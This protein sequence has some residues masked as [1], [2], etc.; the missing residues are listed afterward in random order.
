MTP[1]GAAEPDIEV[2]DPLAGHGQRFLDRFIAAEET[3][4]EDD[5]E[6]GGSGVHAQAAA[7]VCYALFFALAAA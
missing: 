4:R 6:G 2:G 1:C 7:Y 3:P 5:V